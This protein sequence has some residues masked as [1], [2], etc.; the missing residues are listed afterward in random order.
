MALNKNTEELPFEVEQTTTAQISFDDIEFEAEYVDEDQLETKKFYTISGKE[1]MYEPDWEKFSIRE[2]D[3]G[4]TFEGIPEISLFE[5]EDKSYDALRLRL[6]DNGE[7]LDCYLNYPKKDF[8]YVRGINKGFDFYRTCFDFIFSVL[9]LRDE[10]NVVNAN[11]EEV[12]RFK[13]VNLETFAKYVDQHSRVGVRVT[14]GN[15]DS[16]YNSWEIYKME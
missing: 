11:G 13:Q 6:L 2:L 10:R 15:P 4:D 3:V 16:E 1:Q 5:N 9:K 14:E 12:N 8:P 7:I